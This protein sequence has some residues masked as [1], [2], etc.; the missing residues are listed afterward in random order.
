MLPVIARADRRRRAHQRGHHPRRGGGGGASRPAPRWSTTSAAGWPTRTWPSWSPRPACRGCSC[1]G[2]GTAGR[3]TRRAQYGDVV[4]EVCAELTARVEDVVAAGVAPEQLVLDP[5][6]GLRQERRAQ[7]GA[8]GRAGPAGRPGAAG[9]GRR[10]PQ[11]ASSAG[12]SP[13]PTAPSAPAEGG[14]PRRW[15]RR[16][17]PRRP[18]PGACG[19][20]TRPPRWTP[21]ARSRPCG[22]PEEPVAA[23]SDPD[24]IAA[25]R[26]PRPRPPRRLRVR[27]RAR[28]DVHAS[29]PC[30]RSTPR[31]A[32]AGDDLDKTVNYAELAQQLYARPHRRAGRP[33]RDPRPAAGRRLPGLPARG[34][35]RDHRA[36]AAGRARGAVRRRHGR[37]PPGRARDPGGALARRQPRRPRR[38][39]CAPR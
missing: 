3:C 13:T 21:S 27:A 23:P 20:T 35:R 33:A 15:P 22:P 34:R 11:D 28:A 30:W 24:R 36:Q 9:A 4:T 17:W 5:G 19:C 12:C 18:A 1:T 10:L 8:A 37:H 14:T 32:A 25:A 6:L 26:G 7:L 38:R 29:T 39:R 2:A 16:C 31:A